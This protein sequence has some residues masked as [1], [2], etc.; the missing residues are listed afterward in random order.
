M[1][2]TLLKMTRSSPHCEAA[3]RALRDAGVSVVEVNDWREAAEELR[4]CEAALVVCNPELGAEIDTAGLQ[5]AVSALSGD[6]GQPALPRELARSL[7]H[8]LRTPLSAMAGWVH[9]L[10]SGALDAAGT[11]RAIT[12]LRGNIDE[13]VRT[14]ERYLGTTSQE[15]PRS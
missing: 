1:A 14:I 9:L 6:A 13:Q 11:K 2:T 8:D 4:K 5:R 12:K 10:E 15:G 3:S 7:S